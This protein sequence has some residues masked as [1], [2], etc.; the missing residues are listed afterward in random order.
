MRQSLGK[1]I[2][3]ENGNFMSGFEGWENSVFFF[4]WFAYPNVSG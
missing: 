2:E 1:E 4:E 3:T